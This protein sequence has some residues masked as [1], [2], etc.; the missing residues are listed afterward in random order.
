MLVVAILES[1]FYEDMSASKHYLGV[2]LQPISTWGLPA[3]QPI[4]N[5]PRT[6]RQAASHMETKAQLPVCLGPSLT[7]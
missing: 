7:Y 4:S 6:P 5:N 3:Q 2:F 1:L